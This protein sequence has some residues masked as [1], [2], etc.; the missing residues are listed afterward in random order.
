[1]H[2]SYCTRGKFQ[3]SQWHRTLATKASDAGPTSGVCWLSDAFLCSVS[4]R[5]RALHRTLANHY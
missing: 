2:L 1:M 3:G 5:L 4:L